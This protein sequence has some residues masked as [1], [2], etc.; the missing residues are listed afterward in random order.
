M[1]REI[2]SAVDY[3]E[4]TAVKIEGKVKRYEIKPSTSDGFY[5]ISEDK[6]ETG[7][8]YF[9]GKFSL[10]SILEDIRKVETE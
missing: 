6:I 9:P 2:I 3:L 4:I 10:E 8:V 5:R 1:E 7:T